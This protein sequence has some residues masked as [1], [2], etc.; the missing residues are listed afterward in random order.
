ME[1]YQQNFI[2]ASKGLIKSAPSSLIPDG[3]FQ[4]TMNVRFGDGY[5]EKVQAFKPFGDNSQDNLNNS[6]MFIGQYVTDEGRTYSVIH[7]RDGVYC[8]NDGYQYD[9]ED[10]GIGSL[11]KEFIVTVT[12]AYN[13]KINIT[14]YYYKDGVKQDTTEENNTFAVE[15]PYWKMTISAEVIDDGLIP[16]NTPIHW[17]EKFDEPYTEDDYE[18]DPET[19][20]IYY[21]GGFFPYKYYEPPIHGT[22]YVDGVAYEEGTEIDINENHVITIGEPNPPKVHYMMQLKDYSNIMDWYTNWYTPGRLDGEDQGY[23]VGEELKDLTLA[24]DASYAFYCAFGLTNFCGYPATWDVQFVTNMAHMFDHL[25]PHCDT[26]TEGNM[27]LD[28]SNWNTGN[29][30]DMESMFYCWGEYLETQNW[31]VSKVQNMKNMFEMCESIIA[32]EVAD[33]DTSSVTDMSGMFNDC[34]YC[35]LLDVSKW[36]T[37]NVTD[38]KNMFEDC[39]KNY[40][41]PE[42]WGSS[43]CFDVYRWKFPDL[44]HSGLDSLDLS[45]WDTSKVT[46]MYG[47][48]SYCGATVIDVSN[49]DTS[50]IADGGMRYM[51]EE[52][53]HYDEEDNWHDLEYLIIDSP[54]FK[55]EM[56]DAD[57]GDLVN[58]DTV[59]IL[60]PSALLS[61]YQ[62]ATNWSNVASKFDA[63]ENYTITRSNGQVTVTPNT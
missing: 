31:D 9:E 20:T 29:V 58:N 51:F 50:S 21:A 34:T 19:G 4:E 16:Y 40:Y 11:P 55:F 33:W 63:I 56:K 43:P 54:T 13:Q 25:M 24:P 39:G 6:I 49:W 10:T 41:A 57:C 3:A 62:S 59:K 15:Q 36:D 61:T 5:V 2:P 7:T 44:T 38:M 23:I 30:T 60:V 52:T 27:G 26:Q 48:F 47:M 17:I 32:F 35:A 45:Q 42:D 22:I 28:V 12:P 8:I 1:I 53:G 46:S 14:K 37:S 18:E